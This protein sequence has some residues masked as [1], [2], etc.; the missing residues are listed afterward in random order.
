MTQSSV[1]QT[2]QQTD[3][4][5]QLIWSLYHTSA[6]TTFLPTMHTA[7]RVFTVKPQPFNRKTLPCLVHRDQPF[8]PL[9][10]KGVYTFSSCLI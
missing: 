2:W 8:P 4:R 7:A 3:E 1:P 10:W 9:Q 6:L 5:R